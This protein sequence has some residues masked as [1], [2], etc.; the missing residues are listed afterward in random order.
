MI[1]LIR[2]QSHPANSELKEAIH[3]TQYI[4][5]Q[6]LLWFINYICRKFDNN[7][8]THAWRKRQWVPIA[9]QDSTQTKID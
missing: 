6:H 5:T 4:A 8:S 1:G 3:F 9:N 7:K 2:K